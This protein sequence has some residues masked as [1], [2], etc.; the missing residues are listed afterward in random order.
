MIYQNR[1]SALIDIDRATEF[2]GDD[3]D[4]YS[5]LIKFDKPYEKIIIEVPT[6]DSST[7][8]VYAQ[9]NDS[10]STVPLPI[11]YRQTSDNATALWATTAGTGGFRITVDVGLAQFIRIRTGSNQTADRTFYVTGIRS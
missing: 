8:T 7:V 11:H 4:Q 9:E 3:V 5:A 10:I 2:T 6:L 1:Q